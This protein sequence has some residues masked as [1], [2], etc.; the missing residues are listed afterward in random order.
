MALDPQITSP[1]A[2][3]LLAPAAR[4]IA[5]QHNLRR[6]LLTTLVHNPKFV[7]AMVKKLETVRMHLELQLDQNGR[8][9]VGDEDEDGGRELGSDED[10]WSSSDDE[11]GDWDG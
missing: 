6:K 1:K 3:E 7:K 2:L 4:A 9:G 5:E 8:A 10:P 11:A